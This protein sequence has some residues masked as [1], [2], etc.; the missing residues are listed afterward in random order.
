MTE[1]ESERNAFAQISDGLKKKKKRVMTMQRYD[2]EKHER[3]YKMFLSNEI[4][5]KTQKT[6]Q[7]A[8]LTK[9]TCKPKDSL[10]PHLIFV[11]NLFPRRISYISTKLDP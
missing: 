3:I 6:T 10:P 1:T 11:H 4:T 9:I 8:K 5:Q 7:N 2:H